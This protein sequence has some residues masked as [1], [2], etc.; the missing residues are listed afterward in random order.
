MVEP[1]PNSGIF[2]LYRQQSA[3]L[4]AKREQQKR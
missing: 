2:E 1:M 3:E 4:R